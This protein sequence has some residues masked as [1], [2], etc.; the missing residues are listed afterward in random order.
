M[1]YDLAAHILAGSIGIVSGFVALYAAKGARVHRKSGIVF[2]YAMLAMA[3]LGAGIAAVRNVAPQSNVPAGL[4][5]AYLVITGLTTVRP[6]PGWSR[7]FDI[8][9]MLAA[10]AIALA[11]F[12][13]GISAYMSPNQKLHWVIVPFSIFGTIG[14]LASAGDLRMIRAGG[15]KGMARI[16][17][18]LWRM[19][20]ALFI[21]T[22]SFFLGQA[23]VFP[24]AI[25]IP[26]LLAVPVLAVLVT[27]LYW[28]WRV[29]VRG[30][31]RAGAGGER[32]ANRVR[33]T[34]SGPRTVANRI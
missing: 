2:V 7:R 25:R 10:L 11:D 5:T 22:S 23:K 27:M 14:L 1:R 31:Y 3:F 18:H 34:P 29:K 8:A 21:A 33:A 30:T 15:L 17:R 6:I 12:A 26:G 13:L 20:F 19:C 28:M 32:V 16:A 24:K 4:L 9:L